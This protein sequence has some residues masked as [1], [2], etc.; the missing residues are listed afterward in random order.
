MLGP[1]W[2]SGA[3][4]VLL[5][6]GFAV[7]GLSGASTSLDVACACFGRQGRPL[8]YSHALMFPVWAGAAWSVAGAGALR[9]LDERLLV[10]ASCTAFVSLVYVLRMWA[11]VMPLARVWRRAATRAGTLPRFDNSRS[12]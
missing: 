2:Y 3:A 1:S 5:A 7:A 4:P 9:S 10:L 6:A 8:G 12:V 11:A